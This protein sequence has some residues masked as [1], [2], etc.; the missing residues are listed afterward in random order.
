MKMWHTFLFQTTDAVPTYPRQ[1]TS[2]TAEDASAAGA[3]PSGSNGTDNGLASAASKLGEKLR[4]G[5]S[6][7]INFQ[8][9]E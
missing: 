5:I 3:G 9:F 6:R 2:G 8:R 4:M 7:D 1:T